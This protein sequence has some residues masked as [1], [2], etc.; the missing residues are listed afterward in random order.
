MDLSLKAAGAG[1]WAP[2][3]LCVMPQFCLL[4]WQC[5][6]QNSLDRLILFLKSIGKVYV[7]NMDNIKFCSTVFEELR[8]IQNS[9]KSKKSEVFA[10]IQNVTET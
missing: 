7:D 2:K 5:H 9:E 10:L 8:Y 6:T 3:K 1:V 4:L